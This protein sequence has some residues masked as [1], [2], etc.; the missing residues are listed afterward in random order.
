MPRL[1]GLNRRTDENVKTWR[2]RR[3]ENDKRMDGTGYQPDWNGFGGFV[4]EMENKKKKKKK[5]KNDRRYIICFC[6]LL[7][8]KGY[9][10]VWY[11]HWK[12]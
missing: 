11:G 7:S 10:N 5:K 6:F 4:M 12:R 2:T 8:K 3:R 1:V 9:T